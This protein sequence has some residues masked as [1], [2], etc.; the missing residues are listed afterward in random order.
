MRDSIAEIWDDTRVEAGDAWRVEIRKAI[1]GAA[2]A[3]LLISADFLASDFIVTEELPALLE[4]AERRGLRILQ[5]VVSPSRLERTSLAQFQAVNSPDEP[6]VSMNDYRREAL[7][8]RVAQRIESVV[9]AEEVQAQIASAHHRLDEMSRKVS[10]LFLSTMSLAMYQNLTKIV[11]APFGPYEMNAGLKR[12]L[13][14]L[15]T[16]GYVEIMSLS[17]IP[18]SG[19]N[20]SAFVNPTEAGIQF[21]RLRE[22][23]ELVRS[24]KPT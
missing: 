23:M 10:E 24:Q 17:A 1:E 18:R 12:E 20:L 19:G 13:D 6:L 15:R 16:V 4:A 2:V 7:L 22:E 9:R 14:Y 3:V 11:H 8:D 21:V 5:I